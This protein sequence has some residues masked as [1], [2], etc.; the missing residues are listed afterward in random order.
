M[1]S[2]NPSY[3]NTF[4]GIGFW[5]ILSYIIVAFCFFMASPAVAETK[6]ELAAL[7]AQA[8]GPK[9]NNN[10]RKPNKDK[11]NKPPQVAAISPP[12]TSQNA[13][14][15]ALYEQAFG[16]KAPT[17]KPLKKTKANSQTSDLEAMYAKAF[18]RKAP[19]AA[20]S[21]VNVDL[22]VNEAE[23]GEVT[24]YSNKQGEMDTAKTKTLLLLLEDILKEHIYKRIQ[25]EL[26]NKKRT[27]FTTLTKLGMKAEYNSVNLS[28]DLQIKPSLR[29]PRVLSMGK[30]SKASVRDENKITA[31]EISAFLNMYSSLGISKTENSEDVDLKLRLESSYSMGDV[32]FE[33]TTDFKDEKLNVIKTTITYDQPDKLKRFVV[34]SIATGN[35]NFQEN[36]KLDGIRLSKEF[37]LDPELQIRPKGNETFLLETDSEVEVYINNQLHQRFYLDEGIYS[38]Q[39]IGLY[40]GANNIR[41]R[42]KDEFGKVTVKSS[43]QFYD[44]HLLKPDLSLYAISVGMLSNKEA[45]RNNELVNKPLFSGYYQRGLTKHLTMSLDMQFSPDSY[46]LGAE[47]IASVP[48]GSLKQSVAVSGGKDKQ[49]GYAARFQF[50]PN[51]KR[52]LIGL[53]TLRE[54]TLQLDQSI[55]RF[56]TAWTLSSEVRSKEFVML[57]EVAE[58]EATQKRLMAR[59]QTHFSLDLGD[60]WRGSLNLGVSDYYNADKS[61]TAALTATKRMHNGVRWSVGAH[62]DTEDDLSMNL[63]VSIPLDSLG[64]REKHKR[65]KRLDLLVNS[66]DNSYETKLHIKPLSLYGKDS[67]AGS[68]EYRQDKSV[69][70]QQLDLEYRDTQFGAQLTARNRSDLNNGVNTQ[71]LNVGFNTALACIG[72]ECG[73]SR[74]I[75]DSFALVSGPSNQVNPIAVKSGSNQFEYA[76]DDSDLPI[77][78]TGLI[79]GKGQRAVVPLESYRYQKINI[80]ESTLPDGYDPEKTEFEVF[81]R[82]HQGYFIK[83][84]GEPATIVDGILVDASQKPLAYKG[85]QWT[86]QGRQGSKGKTIAFF[87]NKIGRFRM[88]SVPAGKYKLELFDYPDMRTIVI[89]VPNKKGAVHDVGNIV[90]RD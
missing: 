64:R 8:F 74:P 9:A 4:E 52:P 59:V 42:I 11:Q 2:Q 33:N 66:K 3:N 46:L 58:L 24:V 70:Q 78:Y 80:D 69:R 13:N 90:I 23:I 73:F 65:K 63:Q 61:V 7:Y 60:E 56:F 77:N 67:L 28:L 88:P 18:G 39:D 49:A 17:K 89:N 12:S 75:N 1:T 5:H 86:P 51:I 19:M 54:D 62:Y 36:L 53:D 55:G 15:A 34:G 10:N 71:R 16:Q 47:A 40:E 35:R 6:E 27:P 87:S 37:F 82:Y 43:Q 79:K 45:Y 14:M 85:G 25:K 57:N 68:L 81:P 44:S 84:G 21:Q 48:L 22:R 29:K 31:S 41:V 50:K 76:D 38:L 72:N 32:V 26:A 20:P 83:A 30:K